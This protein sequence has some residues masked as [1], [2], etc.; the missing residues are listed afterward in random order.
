[1]ALHS[2]YLGDLNGFSSLNPSS[3]LMAFCSVVL[4]L[5]TADPLMPAMGNLPLCGEISSLYEDK[6]YIEQHLTCLYSAFL[7]RLSNTHSLS[8]THLNLLI[9]HV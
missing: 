5:R 2:P 8:L 7:C 3:S 6:L 4:T 9:S 1:M